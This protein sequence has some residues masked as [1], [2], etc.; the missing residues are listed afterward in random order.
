M[1]S[2]KLT[3]ENLILDK[4][5]SKYSA[6]KEITFQNVLVTLDHT[7][8]PVGEASRD[9]ITFSL[10][11]LTDSENTQL[12]NI[13]KQIIITVKFTSPY[14]RGTIQTKQM[15]VASNIESA[16]L[17]DSCSGNRYYNGGEITLRALEAEA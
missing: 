13:L 11:P 14:N 2:I 4:K 8:H 10:R 1:S 16:F 6:V 17:I 3:L 12:Y 15:R 7:E 9:V 5:L